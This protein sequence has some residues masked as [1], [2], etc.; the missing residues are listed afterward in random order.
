M[1][2]IIPGRPHSNSVDVYDW[3]LDSE[4]GS[5][6]SFDVNDALGDDANDLEFNTD[7]IVS[8]PVAKVLK[9]PLPASP[10]LAPKTKKT[11][12]TDGNKKNSNRKK[13]SLSTSS[14]NK[15]DNNSKSSN[16]KNNSKNKG[17]SNNDYTV[18]LN[19]DK[20][21][22]RL[23]KN[24][25]S[26]RD[27]RRRKKER[28]KELEERVKRL[29][30]QNRELRVQLRIGRESAEADEAEKWRITNQ[31]RELVKKN[32]SDA[33]IAQTIDMF[34]DRYADYGQE[35]RSTIRYHIDQLEDLLQPTIVT[36]MGLWSLHQEDDFYKDKNSIPSFGQSIW[37]ILCDHLEVTE[38]QKRRIM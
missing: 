28:V 18:D 26:A 31:I 12:N 9:G 8:V 30:R 10:K 15:K 33:T 6:A 21:L 34:K 17:D 1:D 25:Q 24:R 3:L 11:R 22:S 19:D 7:N 16:S 27:C 5:R 29:E 14:N 20:V 13:S 35:R 32:E 4:T 23:E 2:E 37:N 36:K 38:M